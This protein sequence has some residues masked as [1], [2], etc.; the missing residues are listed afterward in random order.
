MLEY[1]CR[2]SGIQSSVMLGNDSG[3]DVSLRSI[4]KIA[5]EL[6]K[7]YEPLITFKDLFGKS[8]EKFLTF[9]CIFLSEYV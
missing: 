7:S 4:N 2:Q 6:K 5:R 1:L 3:G 9:S 8:S